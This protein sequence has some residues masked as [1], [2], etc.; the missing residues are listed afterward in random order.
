MTKYRFS[1]QLTVY[2][3][4]EAEAENPGDY[5]AMLE[6]TGLSTTDLNFISHDEIEVNDW[7]EVPEVKKQT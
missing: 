1:V 2:G 6:E 4:I 3:E 5:A 7:Y